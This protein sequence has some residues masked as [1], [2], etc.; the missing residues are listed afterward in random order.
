M[1]VFM[2]VEYL[3]QGFLIQ[4]TLVR[5][6][7]TDTSKL[8]DYAQ[9]LLRNIMLCIQN[10]ESFLDTQLDFALIVCIQ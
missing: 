8:R 5:R 9:K 1:K 7:G 2:R 6:G 4:R 3:N 10:R